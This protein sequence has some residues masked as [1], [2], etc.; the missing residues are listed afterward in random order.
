MEPF[1]RAGADAKDRWVLTLVGLLG[2]DRLVPAINNQINKWVDDNRGKLAEYA[3][4]ALALLGTDAAL[5]T[6]DALAMRYRNKMKN[7]GAAATEAFTAAAE[8]CGITPEELGDRVVPWLGFDAAYPRQVLC[9]ATPVQLS[10]AMDFKLAYWDTAKKKAVTSLPSSASKEL[11][12]E[13]KELGALLR[14]VV[15]A[16][17]IRHEALMVRQYAWPAARWQALYLAHPL[18]RPFGVRLVWG[19]F[20]AADRLLASFRALEDGTLTTH[21]DTPL[22]L[23]DTQTVRML[24]P[25]MLEETARRAWVTS[26]SDYEITPPFPQLER[27]LTLVS[28]SRSVTSSP[29]AISRVP[30]SMASPSKGVRKSWAGAEAP[31]ATAAALRVIGKVS[32][33]PA[34]MPFYRWKACISA[35][36]SMP[37][38]PSK[39]PFS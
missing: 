13:C 25:L 12:E 17:L 29:A 8:A 3:V 9:G 38:S 21:D 10:I 2:D 18:L 32:P 36:M 7:V 26:L 11:K 37:I 34:S 14:E 15:K 22:E 6:V 5:M 16:Q 27:P 19:V 30:N 4:A 39:T 31:C 23:A 20:D 1:P 35:S 33:R 28:P 24:H